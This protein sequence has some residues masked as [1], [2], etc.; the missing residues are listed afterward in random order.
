MMVQNKRS[1]YLTGENLFHCTFQSRDQWPTVCCSEFPV[2]LEELEITGGGYGYAPLLERIA[3]HTG[4]SVEYIVMAEG[5]SMAYHLA[6]AALLEPGDEV[7]IEEP[8]YGLLLDVAHY[9]G[10][11]VR[12]IAARLGKQLRS[13]AAGD[14]RGDH[15]GH[16]TGDPDQPA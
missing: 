7:V 3:S 11:H 8:T 14:G 9:L 6:M 12:R 5:T 15:A 2:Q 13:L 1:R 4:A 10:A 16:A